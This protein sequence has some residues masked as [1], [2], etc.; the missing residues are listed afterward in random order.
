MEYFYSV[1]SRVSKVAQEKKPW[2]KKAFVAGVGGAAA[3]VAASFLPCGDK[4]DI[5]S[6][7]AVGSVGTFAG[8][9][10]QETNKQSSQTNS[11]Q[12]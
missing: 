5:A 3:I 6:L 9:H 12:N 10:Y 7:T 4:L 2:V 11:L 8:L 1:K